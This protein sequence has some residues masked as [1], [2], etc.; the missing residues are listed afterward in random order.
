MDPHLLRTFV[1]VAHCGSFSDA[2]RQLGYTQSAVSQH[3]AALEND[4]GAPLLNRRPVTPTEAG[5]RLLE[6]AAPILLRLEVA[7]ADVLRAA[8]EPPARLALAA[9]PTALT[10]RTA[11]ALTLIRRATPR[12]DVTV[13]V[14]GRREAVAAVAT[15]ECSLGLLDGVAAPSD[16]LR[17]PDLGSLTAVAVAEDPLTA[18]LPEEH[19]LARRAGLRLDD[20]L[21]ARWIDAPDTAAPL[22]DLRAAAASDAPRASI[23]YEGTDVGALVALVAAGHGIAILPAA[24]AA[25]RPGVRAVPVTSPRLVHRTELLHGRVAGPAAAALVAALTAPPAPGPGAVPG[26]PEIPS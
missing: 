10:G 17:L 4:L 6:H 5:T 24:A 1:A 14:T 18:L 23:R 15:G 8:T 3:I 11:R 25:G 2:A 12:L 26:H 22:P 19:P 21:D 7:R 9:T 13:R 20:L 16:P